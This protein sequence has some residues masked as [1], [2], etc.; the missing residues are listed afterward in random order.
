[1]SNYSFLIRIKSRHVC[2]RVIAII[3]PCL[4]NG[5]TALHAAVMGG[6]LQTVLLL[7]RANADPSVPNQVRTTPTALKKDD[8]GKYFYLS[9]SC[10]FLLPQNNELPAD[11]TKS[12]RILKALRPK[13]MNGESWWP[14]RGLRGCLFHFDDDD[15]D[16][17]G[18][19]GATIQC[20]SM[21]YL[22]CLLLIATEY[23]E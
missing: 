16:D 19:G 11:L 4:Q 17:E 13:V 2:F 23:V 9:I 20:Q 12:D 10:F 14:T 15:D 3:F 8:R 21:Y 5:S 22:R 1:M 7:L 6:N 18:K